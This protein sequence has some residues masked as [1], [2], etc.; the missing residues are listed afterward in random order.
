MAKRNVDV[1]NWVDSGFKGAAVC[2]CGLIV[3]SYQE[4]NTTM[5]E[6]TSVSRAIE[7]RV[8]SIEA[9][10]TAKGEQYKMF[11]Q[12]MQGLKT[13]FQGLK[14]D[15]SQLAVRFQTMADFVAKAAPLKHDK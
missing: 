14:V 6:L 2:I 5:K 15:F 13:D 4:L 3:Y 11:V 10:R 9:D 1:Q 8:T 12:E 7:L